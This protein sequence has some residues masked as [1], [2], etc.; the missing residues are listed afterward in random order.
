MPKSN[1]TINE[2]L[3]WQKALNNRLSELT[4]LRDA[5][6]HSTLQHYG[7]NADKTIESHPSYDVL[8]LDRV[9]N[10]IHRELR[11]LDDAIKATNATVSVN[12]Y[13]RD[14]DVLGELA[15]ND[16]QITKTSKAKAK[17]ASKK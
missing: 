8:S 14:E 16:A 12:G 9:I 2:A 10:G 15:V 17:T 4:R 7:A 1:V 13:Q 5:N 6:S 3:N 11:L